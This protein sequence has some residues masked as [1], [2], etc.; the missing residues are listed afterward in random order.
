[1]LFYFDFTPASYFTT[2][3][4]LKEIAILIIS[5][6]FEDFTCI[7]VDFL[8]TKSG[9]RYIQISLWRCQIVYRTDRLIDSSHQREYCTGC[10]AYNHSEAVSV[11]FNP[12]MQWLFYRPNTKVLWK[13]V[14][15]Q[16]WYFFSIGP[17]AKKSC[18]S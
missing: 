1:M 12:L 14:K 17:S 8:S 13:V 6:F 18:E 16:F 7:L 4:T 3:F 2:Q 15:L 9:A 11:F 5:S 10:V